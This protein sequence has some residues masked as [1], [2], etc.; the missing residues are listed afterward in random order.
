MGTVHRIDGGG[1]FDLVGLT[2]DE[3]TALAHALDAVPERSTD[4]ER[5]LTDI[6]RERGLRQSMQARREMWQVK[7]PSDR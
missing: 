4:G 2:D 3:L 7:D 6:V 5:L 1:E